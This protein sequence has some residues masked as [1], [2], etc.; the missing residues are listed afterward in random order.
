MLHRLHFQLKKGVIQ[1]Q[2]QD[3]QAMADKHHA[4]L[5]KEAVAAIKTELERV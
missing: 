2:L 1:Q 5:V 3:W 4:K